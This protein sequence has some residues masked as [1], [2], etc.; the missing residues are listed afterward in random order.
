MSTRHFTMGMICTTEERTKI[1]LKNENQTREQAYQSSYYQ[2][3]QNPFNQTHKN[4]PNPYPNHHISQNSTTQNFQEI[5]ATNM[6]NLEKIR[7][8]I[9]F[10]ED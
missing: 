8:P 2:N 9:P 10:L 5:K 4:K 1:I 3:Q 7:K 6:K